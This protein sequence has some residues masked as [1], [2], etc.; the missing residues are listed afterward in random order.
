MRDL[1]K[2]LQE[3]LDSIKKLNSQPEILWSLSKLKKSIDFTKHEIIKND[4]T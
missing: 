3:E 2:D 1:L 4:L